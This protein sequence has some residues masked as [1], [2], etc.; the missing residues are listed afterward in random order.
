VGP[1]E[2]FNKKRRAQPISGAS[3]TQIGNYKREGESEREAKEAERK[4][5]LFGSH[6]KK[7]TVPH[8]TNEITD[9]ESNVDVEQR[10]A[11]AGK[12]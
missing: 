4:L 11:R 8:H 7:K 12:C 9:E 1:P 3:R 2:A 10:E 6:R 5:Q